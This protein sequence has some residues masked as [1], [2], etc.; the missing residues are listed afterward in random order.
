MR[1]AVL[2]LIVSGLASGQNPLIRLINDPI[3]LISPTVD[4]SAQNV[5]FAAATTPD[6]TQ[7]QGTNLYLSTEGPLGSSVRPLTNYAGGSSLSGVSSVACSSDGGA[8]AFSAM[9]TGP[10]GQEEVHLIDVSS[11]ADRT[12]AIDQQGCVQ[13]LCANCF[14]SCIGSVHLNADASKV[15]Y[16]VARQ[17]P[18]SVVNS[19]GT[20]LTQ[21][22]V[23][24]GSLA[25]SP[26]RVISQA[27][28]FVFTSSAP[29]GPTFAAAATDVYVMNLDGTGLRQVTKFGNANFFAGNATVSADGSLIAF[30]SNFSDNAPQPVNQIWV[31]HPDGTGLQQLSTGPDGAS[32][33]S[34]SGDGSVVLFVQSGLITR[35]HTGGDL[36]TLTN[37]STS[38]A[39]DPVVSADGTQVSF[40]LGPQFGSAAAVYRIPT[41][42]ASDSRAFLGVYTPHRLN[43]NGVASAA[44]NGAPS[45]GS[46]ISV[47]GVQL[48]VDELAQ[49]KG[50]PLPTSLGSLSLLVNGQPV[51]LLVVTP[52]Q[53]NAQLPQTLA[54]GMATFQVSYNGGLMSQS[55]AAKIQSTS[56][57]SFAYPFTQG[58]LYYMQAAAFH[59]GT[60]IAADLNH[61]ARAGETLEIYG[62][63][64]GV[65]DPQVAAGVASPASPPARAL[66]APSLQ[67]GGVDATVTF[68]GLVPG[69]AG[70]YQVN[71]VVPAGL[72]PGLQGLAWLGPGGNVITASIAVQ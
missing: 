16:Q 10:G 70:V 55:S 31:V 6:S 63:G 23:Y 45:P 28:F 26:Q 24:T 33:P 64:L 49:A 5:F 47:Y 72:P 30:E 51:P 56:P 68:A 52:W 44:G 35:A 15:L 18:F 57:E 41:D 50:F 48:G 8:A 20:G 69:I 29:S 19:D 40:T 21:L 62:L 9:P 54:P 42:S 12:L 71:A 34:I 32:S 13:P 17:P 61:P 14:L 27:G 38:T 25:P 39:R 2:L 4:A 46:L 67:I 11:G 58:P 60:A 36:L 22:P 59:A 65:T 37:L 43:S 3:N 1:H 53:I 66:Q 7:N